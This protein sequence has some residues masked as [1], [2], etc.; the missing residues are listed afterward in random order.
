MKGADPFMDL[1]LSM[2]KF[3]TWFGWRVQLGRK[4]WSI[5]LLCLLAGVWVLNQLWRP[6]S[7]LD[8]TLAWSGCRQLIE[9]GDD[10]PIEEV[11]FANTAVS[12]FLL[13]ING[14][15][16]LWRLRDGEKQYENS[17]TESTTLALS[18]DGLTTAT[19]ID[20]HLMLWRTTDGSFLTKESFKS[21]ISSLRWAPSGN[22]LAIGTV[23]AA[24]HLWNASEQRTERVLIPPFPASRVMDLA[25][26][27]DSK[28]LAAASNDGTISVWELPGGT[29]RHHLLGH[30][31]VVTS[32]VYDAEGEVLISGAYDRTVRIWR[33]AD[34]ALLRTLEGHSDVIKDVRVAPIRDLVASGSWD[35]TVRL[36]RLSDGAHLRTLKTGAVG[37]LD[38]SP[39][40]RL[41]AVG[42]LDGT[43]QIWEI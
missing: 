32:V 37:A 27:P 23:P 22:L 42:C 35:G 36:W 6:C 41:L 9:S 43:I 39:D 3:R 30:T 25:F 18:A 5:L 29:L 21:M 10:R 38:F 40:G 19:G 7:A 33:A 8:R 31:D 1:S 26:S 2:L 20:R 15:L 11:K 12:P 13:A 28:V 34:G 14:N 17:A 4:G 16:H 24:V